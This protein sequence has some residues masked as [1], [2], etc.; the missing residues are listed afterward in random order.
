MKYL[1]FLIAFST[2]SSSV[3]AENTIH[4]IAFF[5]TTEESFLKYN[6]SIKAY[7]V[8]NRQF[9]NAARNTGMSYKEY[10]YMNSDFKKKNAMQLL[11]Q[12]QISSTDVVVFAFYS[13]GFRYENQKSLF[14]YVYVNDDYQIDFNE[15]NLNKNSLA[16]ESFFDS[17]RV[18]N[19][20]LLIGI[21][22]ACNASVPLT[23]PIYDKGDMLAFGQGI[24]KE[25]KERYEDLFLK[26]K[27]SILLSSSS[28]EEEAISG[29]Y[30]SAFFTSFDI[31]MSSFLSRNQK[32]KW[33]DLLASVKT[34]TQK[35]VEMR[36]SRKQTP[37]YNSKIS[38]V[39]RL[40]ITSRQQISPNALQDQYQALINE[41][42]N[43][44]YLGNLKKALSSFQEALKLKPNDALASYNITVCEAELGVVEFSELDYD[45]ACKLLRKIES[46]PRFSQPDMRFAHYALGILYLG[47]KKACKKDLKKAEYWLNKSYHEGVV[48]ACLVLGRVYGGNYCN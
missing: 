13:H 44:F 4:L 22:D 1:I 31:Q 3:I 6:S 21:V 36:H 12:L 14:P 2:L 29:N 28:I 18:K 7:D 10:L 11:R 42:T 26:S 16:A 33:D 43:Y 24:K 25:V 5:N 8:F 41:G 35:I 19:P 27:G 15:N 34:E 39:S 9:K 32:I 46:T 17:L 47:R 48:K 40:V 30:G 23:E 45:E 37:Y 20:R 38:E